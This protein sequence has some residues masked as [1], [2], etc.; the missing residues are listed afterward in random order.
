MLAGLR[1]GYL[2][3]FTKFGEKVAYRSQK[4][5]Y[6]FRQQARS[7]NVWLELGLQL[8]FHITA[9]RTVLQFSEPELHLATL[10]MTG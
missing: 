10:E 5:P 7:G 8:S 3:N 6:R 2:T 9:N 1:K 4:N